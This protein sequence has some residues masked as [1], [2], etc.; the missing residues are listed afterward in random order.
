MQQDRYTARALTHLRAASAS[1]A[2]AIAELETYQRS[3]IA[4]KGVLTERAPA[5]RP[6]KPLP[7]AHTSRPSAPTCAPSA[8]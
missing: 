6:R 5:H 7:A 1:T 8:A 2:A 3:V 4:A